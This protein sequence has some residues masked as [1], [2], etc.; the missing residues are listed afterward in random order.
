MTQ[1]IAD[2]PFVRWES[3]N[4]WV[5]CIYLD[6]T[7]PDPVGCGRSENEH[8]PATEGEGVQVSA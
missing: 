5:V 4:G 7:G 8:A 2:H 3:S 6:R 1:T